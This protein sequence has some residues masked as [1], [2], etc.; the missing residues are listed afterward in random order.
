MISIH[1]A[2]NVA[3][4]HSHELQGCMRY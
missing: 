4:K 1:L 2:E 3:D